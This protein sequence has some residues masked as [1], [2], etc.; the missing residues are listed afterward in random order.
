MKSKKKLKEIA[1]RIWELE[2]KMP[3][4]KA[5]EEI[6]KISLS[7]SFLEMLEVDDYLMNKVIDK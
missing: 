4:P 6:V 3:D 7:L 2:Q 5:E 1:N